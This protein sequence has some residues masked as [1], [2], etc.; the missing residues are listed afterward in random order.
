MMLTR[1]C[2]YMHFRFATGVLQTAVGVLMM[3]DSFILAMASTTVIDLALNLTALHFIQEI[4]EVGFKLASMGLV[5]HRIQKHCKKIE[6]EKVMVPT[7]FQKKRKFRQSTLLFV[8]LVGLLV[9]YFVVVGWQVNGIFICKRVYI[10]FSED[11]LPEW[12]FYSGVF[13]TPGNGPWSRINS[14]PYYVDVATDTLQ[15]AYCQNEKAWTIAKIQDENR[16]RTDPCESILYMSTTTASFDITDVANQMWGAIEVNGDYTLNQHRASMLC[17]DCHEESCLNGHCED[18]ICRCKYQIETNSSLPELQWLG[19]NCDLQ[20]TVEVLYSQHSVEL[21]VSTGIQRLDAFHSLSG[22]K[23]I[24]LPNVQFNG[25]MVYFQDPISLPFLWDATSSNGDFAYSYSTYGWHEDVY[26]F[27]V[28]TGR[29]WFVFRLRD[30]ILSKPMKRIQLELNLQRYRFRVVL[31]DLDEWTYYDDSDDTT[32]FE[33]DVVLVS[34][35]ITVGSDRYKYVAA[36]PTGLAWQ[37]CEIFLKNGGELYYPSKCT[38][39]GNSL[40]A[41]SEP[42]CVSSILASCQLS[43]AGMMMELLTHRSYVCFS[44]RLMIVTR[45][46]TAWMVS[47]PV[48]T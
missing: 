25:R 18:N 5:N 21:N 39:F 29:R 4:D 33:Y 34:E 26:S 8:L 22:F 42:E 16:T 7:D 43:D 2:R 48:L 17:V 32:K 46:V 37:P 6:G 40:F 13:Q 31:V 30:L 28:F 15:L 3:V 38:T 45:L 20:P 24:N 9:P 11:H 23:F 27:V 41:L 47:A 44:P 36:E 10:E 14:R 35:P 12:S 1:F 19:F